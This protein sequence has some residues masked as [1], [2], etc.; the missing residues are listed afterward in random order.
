MA[1]KIIVLTDNVVNVID[2][3]ADSKKITEGIKELIDTIES[4]TAVGEDA[5]ILAYIKERHNKEYTTMIESGVFTD[6]GIVYA[7]KEFA[8][9]NK[10]TP[11]K[12]VDFVYND[13]EGNGSV[14]EKLIAAVTMT[15]GQKKYEKENN[16]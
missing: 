6:G 8:K 12:A 10:I 5:Q 9:V 16:K 3:D 2:T 4:G 7:I 11:D 13:L 15:M 14:G 1:T